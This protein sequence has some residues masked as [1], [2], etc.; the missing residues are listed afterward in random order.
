MSH[1]IST[2]FVGAFAKI[3]ITQGKYFLPKTPKMLQEIEYSFC[4]PAPRHYEQNH[5]FPHTRYLRLHFFG[6]TLSADA[7]C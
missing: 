6:L 7:M 3:H 5:S 1:H 4:Y 2:R